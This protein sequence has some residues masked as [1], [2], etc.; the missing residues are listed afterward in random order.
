LCD[1]VTKCQE[2]GDEGG[3][4]KNVDFLTLSSRVESH[5]NGKRW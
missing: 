1:T 4:L 2:G 5:S 3:W